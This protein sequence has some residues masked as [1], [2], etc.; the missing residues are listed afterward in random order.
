MRLRFVFLLSFPFALLLVAA[1][2]AADDREN[3]L[4]AL[5]GLIAE[6]SRLCLT[7]AEEESAWDETKGEWQAEIDLLN[8]EKATLLREA[9]EADHADDFGQDELEK[10]REESARLSRALDGLPSLLGRAEADLKQWPDRLPPSLL[11]PLEPAFR[12]L[13]N[14]EEPVAESVVI[15]LQRVLALYA[16]IERL[17]NSLHFVK[18]VLPMP[19]GSAREVDLCYVGLARGFGVSP[20]GRW[21]GIGQP[22]TAEWSWQDRPELAA[23][24]RRVIE[25]AG[26]ERPAALVTLPIAVTEAGE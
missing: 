8:R 5:A 10:V 21:A 20:D 7:L 4:P 9:D 13:P 1:S 2:P 19:D 14:A 3:A 23:R 25:I 15:R 18:E 17:Q 11:E 12:R 26:K 24:I 6:W 22:S 16:E